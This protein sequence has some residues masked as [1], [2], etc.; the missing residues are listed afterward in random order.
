MLSKRKILVIGDSC[1]D[2][3]VYCSADR[4]APDV[5]VPIL[6]PISK[7]D[8]PGMAMNLYKNL[9]AMGASVD[10]VTNSN[11]KSY[12]KTRYVDLETNHMFFRVDSG[13]V[14]AL[15][16]LD[17]KSLESYYIV[18]ISDYN[19]GFLSNAD[20]EKI[21]RNHERVFIDTKKPLGTF[22]LLAKHIKINRKEYEAS[23]AFLSEFPAFRDRAVIK[24]DGANG[25]WFG[26]EQYPTEAVSISDVSGAGDTFFA[27]LIKDYCLQ[28]EITGAIRQANHRALQA[29]QQ[30][31]VAVISK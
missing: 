24:T 3:F 7:T 20:I 18:A 31:G 19:K 30:R 15:R 28:G 1:L 25:A 13:S 5:P 17:V 4:L 26:G 21:C 12:K 2:E 29:V 10:I 27:A 11:W 8:N 9:E 22:A 16:R 14:P 23:S 6:K